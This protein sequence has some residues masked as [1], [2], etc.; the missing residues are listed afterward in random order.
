[1]TFPILIEKPGDLK[2]AAKRIATLGGKA[3]ILGGGL[4]LLDQARNLQ[5]DE[6]RPTVLI[7]LRLLPGTSYIEIRGEQLRI[8]A[9]TT[10]AEIAES[11]G[12][13]LSA[14]PLAEA[15]E[16]VGSPQI[17]NQATIAGNLLQR[18]RCWYFRSG[19]PCPKN[20][21][22]EKCP[23]VEGDNR[24]HAIFEGG[25][26]WSVFH[27]DVGLALHAL[28]ASLVLVTPEGEKILPI[29]ELYVD[30]RQTPTREHSLRSGDI[31]REIRVPT[32]TERYTGIFWKV[33]ERAGFDFALASIALVYNNHHGRF[34]DM[35]IFLGGVAPRPY[36]PQPTV[37]FIE[38]KK[39]SRDLIPKAAALAA[40]G[41]EPLA[42][43]AYKIPIVKNLVRKAFEVT[44]EK[45]S[46]KPD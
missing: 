26:T 46:W 25:P 27:S 35:R 36:I 16:A 9:A 12:I 21:G 17:R 42:H 43:N 1:M 45:L 33:T 2:T 14:W 22:A 38:Y 44:Y 7:P 3:A 41:A 37:N 30:P 40:D 31:I 18:P 23:A 6:P 32:L 29:S 5:E 28:K 13:R 39:L 15:A 10:L 11:D 8:G 20:G 24:Y 19:I 34:K 4:D